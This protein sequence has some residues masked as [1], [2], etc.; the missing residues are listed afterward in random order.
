M[1]TVKTNPF[2]LTR[3]PN[4]LRIDKHFYYYSDEEEHNRVK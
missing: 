1:T 4:Y 2:R 3:P